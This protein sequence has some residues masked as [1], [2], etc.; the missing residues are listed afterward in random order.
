[1]QHFDLADLVLSR[2]GGP[3]LLSIDQ[4]LTT[5]NNTSFT[6]NNLS[7][8][9]WVEGAYTLTLNVSDITDLTGHPLAASASD[10]FTVTQSTLNPGNNPTSYVARMNGQNLDIFENNPGPNPT[11]RVKF[12]DLTTLTINTGGGADSLTLDFAGGNPI[13]SGGLFFN[14]GGGTDSLTILGTASTAMTYRP[15]ATT[16]GNGLA[17]FGGRNL[18]FTGMEPVNIQNLSSFTFET[19]NATDTVTIDSPSAGQTRMFGNSSGI[20][21]FSTIITGTPLMILDA[22]ANDGAAGN[23]SLTI[24]SGGT[25]TSPGTTLRILSGAGALAITQ[26]LLTFAPTATNLSVTTNGSATPQPSARWLPR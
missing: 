19:P 11:Y 8:I 18:T 6:L 1:V 24:G 14:G 5:T 17:T 25:N 10:S 7:G 21:F 12:T 15:S 16:S 2:N 20:T 13:P 9:T 23:D 4:S 22:A 26:Q 3:N